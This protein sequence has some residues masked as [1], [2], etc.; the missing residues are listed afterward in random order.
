MEKQQQ[1]GVKIVTTLPSLFFFCFSLFYSGSGSDAQRYHQQHSITE[2]WLQNSWNEPC[3]RPAARQLYSHS[4]WW[5]FMCFWNTSVQ[6]CPR[7]LWTEPHPISIIP[8]ASFFTFSFPSELWL[9]S[10]PCHPHF[11]PLL[12]FQCSAYSVIRPICSLSGSVGRRKRVCVCVCV[13][14]MC[15]LAN[16][17]LLLK[18]P[19]ATSC[20]L[21]VV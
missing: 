14:S 4:L 18:F 3:V 15:L 11:L 8:S 19:R 21:L 17:I 10:L 9:F 20:L 16:L 2:S 13:F 7:V 1:P 5:G 6:L 12:R